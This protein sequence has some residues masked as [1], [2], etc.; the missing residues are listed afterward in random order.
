M[1]LLYS[2]KFY[3]LPDFRLN[4]GGMGSVEGE[5]VEG[6]FF[7]IFILVGMSYRFFHTLALLQ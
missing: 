4:T 3:T 2:L 7:R 6:G 5:G 1:L